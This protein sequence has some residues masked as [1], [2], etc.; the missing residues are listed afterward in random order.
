MADIDFEISTREELETALQEEE[1]Q[2]SVVQWVKKWIGDDGTVANRTDLRAALPGET[3]QPPEIVELK[4]ADETSQR[5][6]ITMKL[7]T[8]FAPI[9]Y[10]VVALK[11]AGGKVND[12]P[13]LV[14]RPDGGVWALALVK[15]PG[16]GS[17]WETR[18]PWKKSKAVASNLKGLSGG[19]V[20][21]FKNQ[22]GT[23]ISVAA[24]TD[25]DID[26]DGPGGSKEKDPHWG[27]GTSLVY[28]N[29]DYC[30]SRHFRG[31][32]APPWLRKEFGV[33][34]GDFAVVSWK[35][36]DL[37]AQVY[38]TGPGDKIGEIS[39]GLAVDLGIY[40][41]RSPETEKHAATKGNPVT[42]LLTIFFPG[43]GQRRAVA[44]DV[45][46]PACQ[47]CLAQ[48]LGE[49]APPE[50][51]VFTEAAKTW[52]QF[53]TSLKLPKEFTATEAMVKTG[54]PPNSPPPR[55]LWPNIVPTLAVLVKIRERFQ[56]PLIFHSTYRNLAYN[57]TRD[58]AAPRS[59]HLAFRAV[60]FH[61]DG[62]SPEDVAQYARSLRGVTFEVALPNLQMSNDVP[63]MSNPP[64]LV[65]SGLALRAGPGGGTAFTFHG[66]VAEYTTFV[67][68]DCRG[69]DTN[70]G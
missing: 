67:H 59:Q 41:N 19:Q 39:F 31:V 1:K 5:A 38:D 15:P 25:A 26:T 7:T 34:V 36:L 2:G 52:D 47:Q 44:P 20:F 62:V 14:C 40:P 42:D 50:T 43:S 4:A 35:G 49:M 63:G 69:E 12:V 64:G 55:H 48:W 18:V 3:L 53:F 56:K 58:G 13:V 9:C 65:L 45:M 17:D 57:A 24:Q 70:W 37:P 28:A 6:E 66:G 46:E 22:R 27:S 68:V 51:K 16:A 8:G 23:G 32:V 29:G 60:D 61:V 54:N 21:V 30:D 11:N 10:S 33:Q